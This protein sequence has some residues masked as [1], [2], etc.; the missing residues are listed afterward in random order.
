MII[1]RTKILNCWCVCT[2][3]CVMC[4]A[5]SWSLRAL[6]HESN[7]GSPHTYICNIDLI[8]VLFY[9]YPLCLEML[10]SCGVN[11]GRTA[12]R[13]KMPLRKIFRKP[14]IFSLDILGPK[15]VLLCKFL[16]Y[17]AHVGAWAL[18]LQPHQPHGWSGPGDVLLNRFSCEEHGVARL[19]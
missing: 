10:F 11:C 17:W 13:I 7:C 19:C 6:R 8:L 9:C 12:G 15:V 3:V 5:G 2:C 16:L 4:R 14:Q 1:G 18:R